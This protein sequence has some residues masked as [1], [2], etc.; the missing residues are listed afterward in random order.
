MWASSIKAKFKVKG[1]GAKRVESLEA[2]EASVEVVLLLAL[3]IHGVLTVVELGSHFL[4]G[5]AKKNDQL[6]TSQEITH[7]PWGF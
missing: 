3:G 4:R 7:P 1:S 6:R 2:V 5:V